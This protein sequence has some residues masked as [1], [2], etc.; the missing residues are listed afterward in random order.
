MEWESSVLLT[1]LAHESE[2]STLPLHRSIYL[3]I[4]FQTFRKLS[5]LIKF[6]KYFSLILETLKLF[7]AAL[8]KWLLERGLDMNA[9]IGFWGYLCCCKLKEIYM[10]YENFIYTGL[11]PVPSL[12]PLCPDSVAPVLCPLALVSAGV[13]SPAVASTN[14]Y[15]LSFLTLPPVAP[16]VPVF[17]P[18]S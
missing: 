1:R 15:M 14:S 12:L 3:L 7:N 13:L 16:I 17:C 11:P 4:F 8:Y 10:L 18:W 9:A 2:S 5:Y 6:V